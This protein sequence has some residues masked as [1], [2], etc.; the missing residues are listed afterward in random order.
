MPEV[1]EVF[2]HD[3][4]IRLRSSF[5]TAMKLL[6]LH[7][8]TQIT[9]NCTR[10]ATSRIT[11]SAAS[12]KN[13]SRINR[14]QLTSVDWAWSSTTKTSPSSCSVERRECLK[15][16][17]EFTDVE[18]MQLLKHCPTLWLSPQRA[19]TRILLQSCWHT[20]RATTRWSGPEERSGHMHS[21]IPRSPS[22]PSSSST[23]SCLRWMSS[24]PSFRL[25]IYQLVMSA[26]DIYFV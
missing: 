19:V 6:F 20:L 10:C 2:S 22:S 24:T 1:S 21:S 4:I 23:S 8:T 3:R 9:T 18:H 25:I 12:L 26:D 13:S 16:F 15:G 5:T 14:W 11:G 7:V 17:E